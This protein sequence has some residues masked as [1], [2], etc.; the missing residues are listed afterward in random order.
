MKLHEFAEKL[1]QLR[2]ATVDN[3]EKGGF[4][5]SNGTWVRVMEMELHYLVENH[6]QPVC[7]ATVFFVDTDRDAR[8]PEAQLIR[9]GIWHT[10]DCGWLLASINGQTIILAK[11][12]PIEQTDLD[13]GWVTD[14][15]R[16]ILRRSHNE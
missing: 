6:I 12:T 14:D 9:A 15:G 1:R 10:Y 5:N 16:L 11:V 8:L 2:I 7:I 13:S 4:V 3:P